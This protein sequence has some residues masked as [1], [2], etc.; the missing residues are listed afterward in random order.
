MA[1]DRVLGAKTINVGWI[2][3]SSTKSL[4]AKSASC[5]ATKSRWVFFNLE[6]N[7]CTSMASIFIAMAPSPFCLNSMQAFS[8]TAPDG[9]VVQLG[10]FA[11]LAH[12]EIVSSGF[13][14]LQYRPHLKGQGLSRSFP[15]PPCC[16]RQQMRKSLRHGLPRRSA[17]GRCPSGAPYMHSCCGFNAMLP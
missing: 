10:R 8:S 12:Q 7:A 3:L 13:H 16:S 2:W 17:Q 4:P 1:H 11:R 14:V 6:R 9:V 5:A 15:A